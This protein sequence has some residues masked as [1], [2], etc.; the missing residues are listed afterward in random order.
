M[1]ANPVLIVAAIAAYFL[2]FKKRNSGG[3]ARGRARGAKVIRINS[4]IRKGIQLSESEKDFVKMYSN[5]NN[6]P[7]GKKYRFRKRT[8]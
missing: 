5:P 4:K 8:K 6:N 7:R 1:K 3:A 2:F